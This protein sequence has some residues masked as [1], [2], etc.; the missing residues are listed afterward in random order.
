MAGLVVGLV[1]GLVLGPVIWPR[2]QDNAI[3]LCFNLSLLPYSRIM[4]TRCFG[5]T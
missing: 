1:V 4:V 3:G 2:H 5:L